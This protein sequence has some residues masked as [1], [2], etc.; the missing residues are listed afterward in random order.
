[1]KAALLALFVLVG[2]GPASSFDGPVAPVACGALPVPG[3]HSADVLDQM[4]PPDSVLQQTHDPRAIWIYSCGD[5]LQCILLSGD[6]VE[7]T[8]ADCTAG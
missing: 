1:M 5:R 2:C 8:S 4:G 7:R 6:V 3:L